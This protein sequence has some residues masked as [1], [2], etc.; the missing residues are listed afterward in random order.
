MVNTT[1]AITEG[2]ANSPHLYIVPME[3][4]E[5]HTVLVILEEPEMA[6]QEDVVGM[7]PI[8]ALMVVMVL[9]E[10]I[11]HPGKGKVIQRAI[12]VNHPEIETQEVEDAQEVLTGPEGHLIIN[13]EQAPVRMET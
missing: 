5:E 6:D 2:T 13:T 12:L 11:C 7:M 3:V 4:M 1:L 9:A 10:L 8:L